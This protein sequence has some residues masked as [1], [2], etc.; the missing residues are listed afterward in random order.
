M[1]DNIRIRTNPGSKET[2]VNVNVNQKFDFIE[3]LS[4]KISQEE[5]YRRFCSDYGAVVGRVIVNQGLGVPNA[6]VAIFIPIDDE[7]KLD[8]E[9][10]GLYPFEVV[11]DK[12]ADGIPYNLLPRNNRGKDDCFTPV[13]T[14]PGKREIQ[15]NPEIDEI[16]CKYYKFTTTTNDAGDFMFFGIPTGTH[17]LHVDADISDMGIL[18]QRPYDIIREGVDKNKFYSPTKFKGRDKDPKPTQIKTVSPQSVTVL[19]FW[20]DTEECEIGITRADVD[21]LTTIIPSAIFMGSIFTDS[22]KNSINKKCRPRKAMGRMDDITSGTGRI[23]M[24]RKT[25]DGGIERFDVEG[26]ELIDEGGAW[27]F[28]VPMNLDYVVTSEDG[29]LVPSGDPTKGIPTKGKYRFKIGLDITGGE[30]RLRTNAKYLVPHNPETYQDSDYTF[31]TTTK[32]SSFAELSW[33][34]IYSVKNNLPRVQ[35]NQ[36]VDNRNFVGIKD[37]DEGGQFNPF[38]F[39]RMDSDTNPLFIILC[40]IVTII[41]S[42]VVILNSII[43][44]LINIVLSII[45]V[46]LKI[47][48]VVIKSLMSFIC[49]VIAF[50]SWKT[51][52]CE[53]KES[54][55]MGCWSGCSCSC[56]GPIVPYIPYIT[57]KCDA[58]PDGKPYAP[59]GWKS[60]WPFKLAWEATL[61]ATDP[62]N[63]NNPAGSNDTCDGF[64]QPFNGASFHYPNDGHPGHAAGDTIPPADAG[65]VNCIALSLAE[66]INVFKFDFYND[67]INGTLYAYLLKYKKKKKGKE[68]FCEHDCDDN[69]FGVDGNQDNNPDNGCKENFILDSC[70]GDGV[71]SK[72]TARIVEGYIKRTEDGELFYAA[73]TKTN[74]YKLWATDVISLGSVF[75]CDWE[76]IPKIY[77][78]FTDTTYNKPPLVPDFADGLATTI[79]ISGF[80]NNGPLNSGS[81]IANVNCIGIFTNTNNCT[82]IKRLCEIGFGL[83]EDRRPGGLYINDQM[84]NED[85]DNEFVRGAFM[86]ANGYAQGSSNI[87]LVYID[88]GGANNSSG[89]SNW[90]DP[91]YSVFRGTTNNGIKQHDNSFYFY[92]GIFPGRTAL[93]KMKRKYFT[94]CI[95]EEEI[96]FYCI[97]TEI[98]ADDDGSDPTGSLEIE[99]VGG[100]A[101]FTYTFTGPT[102]IVNGVNQTFPQAQDPNIPK[103][104]DLY[105]GTYNVRVVDSVGNVSS[106]SFI[107][108]GPSGVICYT[109]NESATTFGG[110]DGTITIN[111]QEGTPNYNYTVEELLNPT[112]PT[113]TLVFVTSGSFASSTIV[114]GIGAGTYIVTVTD[115]GNV[116]TSCTSR[117]T[118]EEPSVPQLEI[119]GT[120]IL[121]YGDANG[122]AVVTASGGVNPGTFSW[123]SGQ[124]TS[125]IINLTPGTY[126]VTYT[127]ANQQQA[128]ASVTI[129]QPP[130]I[131]IGINNLK[132]INCFQGSDGSF[133]AVIGGGTPPY[134]IQIK[135]GGTVLQT[136][137]NQTSG[138]FTSSSLIEGWDKHLSTEYGVIVTDANGCEKEKDGIEI[139]A[140]RTPLEPGEMVML[141]PLQV[142]FKRIE[143]D[144]DGDGDFELPTNSNG[145][146][147]FYDCVF[148]SANSPSSTL[149]L[150]V[151][152]FN[153]SWGKTYNNYISPT[154]GS[155]GIGAPIGRYEFEVY[156]SDN[157][158]TWATTGIVKTGSHPNTTN[159]PLTIVIPNSWSYQWNRKFRVKTISY[160]TNTS[161]NAVSPETKCEAWA[162][163]MVCIASGYG[164]L[165]SA[166]ETQCLTNGSVNKTVSSNC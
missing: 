15:D 128:T 103:I 5:A 150:K 18:S 27:A 75:D 144:D 78:L 132:N 125:G 113:P 94:P 45:N 109:D 64:D 76:G 61:K 87:P 148:D 124:S 156:Y 39:N 131:T 33:N 72:S 98:I 130:Q 115:T 89:Y 44:T 117:V 26:G 99:M 14:F 84:G 50:L 40:I 155:L 102:F 91:F 69:T 82:N 159:S 119:S 134:T 24:I 36:T 139:K 63:V 52:K 1:S 48:C 118:I 25:N 73:Y 107:V 95:P 79:D 21:L 127:D 140:P 135:K 19:P 133:D 6:K 42:L 149:M 56:K 104:S 96:D 38:P 7:D 151:Q 105:A 116:Q 66:A 57:L 22:K 142:R 30:G 164:T 90:A 43:I 137:T 80:D 8:P 54:G 4:L 70:T 9:I 11:T 88:T 29:T 110:T 101:P 58:E 114:T 146:T 34:K 157:G 46:V 111:A 129:T 158:T 166:Q 100:V 67:W 81:L 32:D 86:Y 10:L 53:C 85:I 136:L 97:A 162:D 112:G 62:N 31:D 3:I 126:T 147:D 152:N 93:E 92:F 121:C 145:S 23:E 141:S 51:S 28:Q 17:Y 71:K 37:V 55:C 138:T 47:I 165:D 122:Q 65:W 16:Y 12:D 106:C 123:D 143:V 13:G 74:G 161:G 49:P 41:S 2:S 35:P 68:K 154:P 77:E 20:G 60:P 120:N 163:G 59:G 83:D 108:P 160:M 153:G